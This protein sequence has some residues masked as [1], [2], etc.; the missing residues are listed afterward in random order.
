M[1]A[2]HSVFLFVIWSLQAQLGRK[3]TISVRSSNCQLQR[4]YK[5]QRKILQTY[6][7]TA[8]LPE[9]WYTQEG[10]IKSKRA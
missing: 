9:M 8:E 3:P 5:Q 1:Q 2:S 6:P 7:G 4:L 10:S